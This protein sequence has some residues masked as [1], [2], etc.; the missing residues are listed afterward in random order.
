MGNSVLNPKLWKHTPESQNNYVLKSHISIHKAKIK[1]MKK[2]LEC[3]Q[4]YC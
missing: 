4:K 2:N 3:Q 1:V